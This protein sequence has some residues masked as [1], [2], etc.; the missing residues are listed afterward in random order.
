MLL[1]NELVKP[2]AFAQDC[3]GTRASAGNFDGDRE[4]KKEV[5]FSLGRLHSSRR[6]TTE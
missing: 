2:E 6:T 1:V 5:T 4:V 3:V